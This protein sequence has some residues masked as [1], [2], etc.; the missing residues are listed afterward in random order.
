MSWVIRLANYGSRMHL[1]DRSSRTSMMQQQLGR[2]AWKTMTRTTPLHRA[3][4]HCRQLVVTRIHFHLP[5][6]HWAAC[7]PSQHLLMLWRAGDQPLL[8]PALDGHRKPVLKLAR[9][10]V[11]SLPSWPGA[12]PPRRR[13]RA[14]HLGRLRA[15]PRQAPQR[16]PLPCK[17]PVGHV[18]HHQV[19]LLSRPWPQR[20][21]ALKLLQAPRCLSVIRAQPERATLLAAIV[22]PALAAR[23]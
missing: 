6:L 19:S 3:G 15:H 17:V 20:S 5:S 9:V 14:E 4:E 11:R 7:R 12:V 16:G 22:A 2:A 18:Q 8:M 23:R 21:P 1:F 13:Q 10:P